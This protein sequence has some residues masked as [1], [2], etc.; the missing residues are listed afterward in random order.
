MA[1]TKKEKV[2]LSGAQLMSPGEV[3]KVMD[4][5]TL[6]E[7]RVLSCL[8]AE[9]GKCRADLEILDGPRKGQ[10]IGATLRVQD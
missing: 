1:R 10:R 8:A 9:P 6:V 3:I 2:I 7:C 5:G 4:E